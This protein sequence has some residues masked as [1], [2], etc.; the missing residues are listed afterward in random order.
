MI[1]GKYFIFFKVKHKVQTCITIHFYI[2]K[3]LLT[4][5][6][7]CG[8]QNKLA[9]IIHILLLNTFLQSPFA[10]ITALNYLL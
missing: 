1:N 4:N 3:M 9:T 2:Y 8:Q 10:K 6:D 7:N 5:W